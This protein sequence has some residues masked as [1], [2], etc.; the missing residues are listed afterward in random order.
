MPVTGLSLQNMSTLT[1]PLFEHSNKQ[2]NQATPFFVKRVSFLVVSLITHAEAVARAV[3]LCFLTIKAIFT[4]RNE[5]QMDRL[6]VEC[7]AAYAVSLRSLMALINP[8]SLTIE[9][10]EPLLAI[11]VPPELSD[12]YDRLSRGSQ[13]S[14]VCVEAEVPSDEE[15]WSFHLSKCLVLQESWEEK[16]GLSRQD[17]F[18]LFV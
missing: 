12:D 1:R 3:A 5:K 9:R 15:G 18:P 4:A 17:H 16:I 2:A 11:V 8:K 10:A 13:E 7:A 6:R 14:G